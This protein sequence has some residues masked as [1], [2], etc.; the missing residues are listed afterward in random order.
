MST[1][2]WVS[3]GEVA[4][5]LGVAKDSIY[6][7]IETK[8]LPAKRIGRLWKSKLSEVDAWVNAG[9]AVDRALRVEEQAV[10]ST[11]RSA[12][13]PSTVRRE[14]SRDSTMRTPKKGSVR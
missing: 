12:A 10:N 13:N 4:K 1:E 9:G 11:H 2:S 14:R 8:G 7:W 6:R 5:H 3:V